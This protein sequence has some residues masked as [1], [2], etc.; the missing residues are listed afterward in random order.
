[1]DLWIRR[2]EVE[3]LVWGILK[4][5]GLFWGVCVLIV[6]TVPI[7]TDSLPETKYVDAAFMIFPCTTKVYVICSFV[8][9]TFM[10]TNW[11]T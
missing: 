9:T 6:Q 3:L 11:G 1:M 5:P 8:F 10:G 2:V 7:F 4:S